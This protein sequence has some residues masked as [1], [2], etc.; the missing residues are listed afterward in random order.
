MKSDWASVLSEPELLE[1]YGLTPR[2]LSDLRAKGLAYISVNRETRLYAEAETVAFFA[3][4]L[5]SHRH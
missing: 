1:K 4:L 5:T 2:Q 3:T